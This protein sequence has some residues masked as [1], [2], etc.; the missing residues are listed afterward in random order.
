MLTYT[1]KEINFRIE[2]DFPVSIP[3]FLFDNFAVVEIFGEPGIDTISGNEEWEWTYSYDPAAR[4]VFWHLA[5]FHS[6]NDAV[7]FKLRFG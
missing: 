3:Y 1:E 6:D 5:R 7:E 4:W 2:H